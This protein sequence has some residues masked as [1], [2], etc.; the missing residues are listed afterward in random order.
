MADYE[1]HFHGNVILWNDWTV[2][3]DSVKLMVL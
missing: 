3:K 1:L 2:A